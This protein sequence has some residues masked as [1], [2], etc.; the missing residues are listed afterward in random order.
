MDHGRGAGA[1]DDESAQDALEEEN[2]TGEEGG[3]AL[4]DAGSA[5][6]AE[7]RRDT[8]HAADEG[9]LEAF[10]IF[11]DD[12]ADEELKSPDPTAGRSRKLVLAPCQRSVSTSCVNVAVST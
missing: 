9:C 5:R 12:D 10:G 11:G 3:S 2:V 6:A 7:E 4:A 8:W 1:G